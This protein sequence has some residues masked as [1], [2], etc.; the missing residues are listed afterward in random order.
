MRE[1]IAAGLKEADLDAAI[2]ASGYPLQ[3]TVI[4]RL[5]GVF[6]QAGATCFVQEEW[7]FPD[8]DPSTGNQHPSVRSLDGLI[9][10]EL[11]TRNRNRSNPRSPHDYLRHQAVVLLECKQSELPYIFFLRAVHVDEH[12]LLTGIPHR[13]VEIQDTAGSD[14]LAIYMS[15]SD[16]LGLET[17]PFAD[18]PP[19]AVAMTR[20]LRKG[21][22]FELSGDDTYRSISLPM[23][24][25]VRHYF[26]QATPKDQHMVYTV[27]TVYPLV[28]L[29]SPI[30]GVQTQ[31]DSIS[32]K[33]LP[34]VRLVRAESAESEPFR[35]QTKS[36]CIDIVHVEFINNYAQQILKTSLEV[37]KR[38]NRFAV[39]IITGQARFIIRRASRATR[40]AV[41]SK[42]S[43]YSEC[44]PV[45]T[46]KAF[47][48]A[49]HKKFVEVHKDPV[50]GLVIRRVSQYVKSQTTLD[51]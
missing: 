26:N 17:L 4:D 35:M 10:C 46:R 37:A 45:V 42:P 25:A 11:M 19:T 47:D 20:V 39:P 31:G 38:A 33:L 51:Q 28:V 2:R 43:P 41:A 27:S 24:K 29:R 6:C 15:V 22:S 32:T 34:W 8:D 14:G 40:V 48:E 7:P 3:S 44:R 9:T 5:L 13:E 30:V 12:P 49:M 21:R 18:C 50:G 36:R 16:A 23:S 1:C